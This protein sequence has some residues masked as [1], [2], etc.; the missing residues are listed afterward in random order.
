MKPTPDL[1][2]IELLIEYAA[3]PSNVELERRAKVII[4]NH[5]DN[6]ATAFQ[7][8]ELAMT[9]D[10]LQEVPKLLRFQ[11]EIEAEL[12]SEQRR[13]AATTNELTNLWKAIGDKLAARIELAKDAGAN[14]EKPRI[15]GRPAGTASAGA[16][17]FNPRQRERLRRVTSAMA[18]EI[19]LIASNP[20]NLPQA[21]KKK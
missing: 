15:E 12:F 2:V 8:A 7:I 19:H 20:D 11:A 13:A 17:Q 21:L 10:Q 6:P 5:F 4:A 16:D 1:S 3:D 18:S 9:R 14:A